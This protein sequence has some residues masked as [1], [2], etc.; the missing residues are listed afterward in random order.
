MA[1]SNPPID[2]LREDEPIEP[3][4]VEKL[5]GDYWR[6]IENV[7][8]T[9]D[10]FEIGFAKSGP[11]WPVEYALRRVACDLVAVL[12]LHDVQQKI[13]MNSVVVDIEMLLWVQC[14]IRACS[15][16]LPSELPVNWP[17]TPQITFLGRG[18][19]SAL[20][21]SIRVL[22]EIDRCLAPGVPSAIQFSNTKG[23]VPRALRRTM[24]VDDEQLQQW[25]FAAILQLQTNLLDGTRPE[26]I[27]HEVGKILPC[28]EDEYDR[29]KR[30]VKSV[31]RGKTGDEK[32]RKAKTR[33]IDL[34]ERGELPKTLNGAKRLLKIDGFG[35]DTV[36]RAAH[37][38]DQLKRHFGLDQ[39]RRNADTG[40]LLDE[41]S[42]TL[43]RQFQKLP[44]ESRGVIEDEWMRGDKQKALDLVKTLAANPDAGSTGDVSLIEEA[45]QD[46]RTD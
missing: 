41:L 8:D 7:L 10:Q 12:G 37:K 4:N 3:L 2:F 36:R 1:K 25:Y 42:G 28:L 46:S 43:A 24:C 21:V 20:A 14:T 35:G 22:Q 44:E 9:P 31:K 33:M 17:R 26:S 16:R 45:D 34:R 32:W 19:A 15:V 39:K 40:C 18:G 38:S 11:A 23:I 30:P 27:E 29:S 6:K 13:G 5:I